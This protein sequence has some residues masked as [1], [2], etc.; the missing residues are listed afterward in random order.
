M[1]GSVFAV[2]S[3]ATVLLAGC[4]TTVTGTPEPA[5]PPSGEAQA[6][7]GEPCELLT[8]EE[9]AALDYEDEGAF[10]AGDPGQLLPSFCTWSPLYDDVGRDSLDVYFSVDIP[11]TDYMAG[12]AP[13]WEKEIGGLTWARYPSTVGGES[14]CSLVTELSPSSFVLIMSSDF[15]DESQA[16]E[17]AEEVAPFVSSHLPGGA[18]A[19]IEPREPSPLESVDPCSLLT[20]EQAEELGRRG[21]GDFL[22]AQDSL[23]ARCE[24][25]AADGDRRNSTLVTV[26]PDR[27]LPEFPLDTE[28]KEVE[29]GDRTWLVYP[30]SI[31][32][33]CQADLPVTDHSYVAITVVQGDV[34]EDEL[35]AMVED[36]IPFVTENLPES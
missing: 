22:E 26:A 36:T 32:G 24:W 30:A 7:V 12:V 10:T 21:D 11:L 17:Q 1:R 13:E 8:P 2:L 9:A 20:A 4:T 27:P 3:C 6:V 29:E 25:I 19:T 14:L 23:P 15:A 31:P 28:P 34:E 5:S 33:L 35:C 16:C 18:P